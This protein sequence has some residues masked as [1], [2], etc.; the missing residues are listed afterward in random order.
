MYIAVMKCACGCH[1]V[2][3]RPEVTERERER[4]GVSCDVMLRK[5]VKVSESSCSRNYCQYHRHVLYIGTGQ[6]IRVECACVGLHSSVRSAS[7]AVARS[8]GQ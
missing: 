2:V 8:R 6:D 3:A 5:L 4:H 7:Y 1:T